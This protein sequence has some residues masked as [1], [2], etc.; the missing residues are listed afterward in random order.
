MDGRTKPYNDL[1]LNLTYLT[2]I[3]KNDCIIHMS[4]NNLLGTKNIFGYNY[5]STPGEDGQ[6]AS[7]AIVPTSGTMAVLLIMLSL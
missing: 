2:R 4:I 1:S 7:Q 3:F 5:S 6:Y